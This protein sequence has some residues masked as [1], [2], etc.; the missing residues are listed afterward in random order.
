MIFE[1][2]LGSKA[3]L[4]PLT[5]RTNPV[6]LPQIILT[7]APGTNPR[8]DRCFLV[9]SLHEIFTIE[10]DSPDF[11]NESGIVGPLLSDRGSV[12]DATDVRPILIRNT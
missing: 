2:I 12:L 4:E 10:P 9:S 11:R 5:S 3:I 1:A 6:L 7:V 8:F